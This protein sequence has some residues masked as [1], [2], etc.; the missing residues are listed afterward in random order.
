MS[1][2][3]QELTIA[4]QRQLEMLTKAVG[5]LKDVSGLWTALHAVVKRRL[6]RA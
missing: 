4:M 1:P 6:E 2:E 3:L 5:E